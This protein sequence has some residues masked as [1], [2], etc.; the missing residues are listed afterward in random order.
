M[1]KIKSYLYISSFF[2]VIFPI[3]VLIFG[4]IYT[5]TPYLT[6]ILTELS[7][8]L[9]DF[10]L[11]DFEYTDNC[12]EEK[13]S[14]IIYTVPA[15]EE[16][17]SCA[18]VTKYP[19]KQA[20]KNLV[21]RGRC[22]K[23]NTLNGCISI[24]YFEP[25]NLQKWYSKVFCSKKYLN[26]NGYKNYFKHSVGKNETCEKGY[27]MCGK[28]D[29]T[30]NYLCILEDEN[31][32]VNDIMILNE[33]NDSLNDTYESYKIGNK[34]LYFTNLSFEKPL[35]TKLKTA[36]G[37]LCAGKGYYY[38]DYP[39]FILDENFDLYGCRYK[40]NGSV[41]DQSITK[42]DTK[43]KFELFNDNNFSMYYDR[44]ND[45]CEYPYFSLNAEVFLY[46]KRY[47]G[48]SKKCLKKNGLT[49]DDDKYKNQSIYDINDNLLKN[50]RHHKILIWVSIAAID[51]YLMTSFFIDIDEENNFTNFYIWSGIT[52][53]FYLS[54][55]IIALIGLTAMSKVKKYPLC[56]D[57]YTNSK[58]DL[59]N[60]KSRKMFLN[61]LGLV[62]SIN[63]QLIF[64]VILY[65][66]KRRS[67]LRKLKN[68]ID[69]ESNLYNSINDIN[70][71]KIPLVS[72]SSGSSQN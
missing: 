17:C 18:N 12:P 40:I 43:S 33:R 27:K 50:R 47:I 61:S 28:L 68:P 46:S 54:M 13:Y 32:P 64:T 41:Y 35:I 3:I 20:N 66:F 52:I 60:T 42:L 34:Y 7:N 63:G 70:Q 22:K 39:Q 62:I 30:D 38:S 59:F 37:K 29:D 26:N 72:A 45:T 36:E 4:I 48:F 14:S 25:V 53:P 58:L 6:G 71:N 23:N 55:N 21:F 8:S 69:T 19:Y 15:S 31:C 16:G 9:N 56:N 65:L 24:N 10:P 51:I 57:E 11:I 1:F 49:I 2:V 44:Y 5:N 67:I